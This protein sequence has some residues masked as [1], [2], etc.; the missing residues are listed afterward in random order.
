M[1]VK[2]L[3]CSWC[4]LKTLKFF[5]LLIFIENT[6]LPIYFVNFLTCFVIV[7]GKFLSPFLCCFD[8][9]PSFSSLLFF[10]F[11]TDF[12]LAFRAFP[13][14]SSFITFW[15]P[16]FF[17]HNPVKSEL[18]RFALNFLKPSKILCLFWFFF[19]WSLPHS[20]AKIFQ[21]RSSYQPHIKLLP[22]PSPFL[23]NSRPFFSG[24]PPFFTF[25]SVISSSLLNCDP[26]SAT[27]LLF[28]SFLNR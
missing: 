8:F 17:P 6:L 15:P 3:F 20:P 14:G 25:F 28:Y 21:T 24:Y 13:A 18:H 11:P 12:L 4:I 26:H 19:L 16:P 5:R 23:S 1:S 10:F 27:L 2:N 22:A 9:P 7:S